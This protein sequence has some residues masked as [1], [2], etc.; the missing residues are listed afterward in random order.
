MAGSGGKS[1]Y[2][3][4]MEQPETAWPLRREA[5]ESERAAMQVPR[6]CFRQREPQGQNVLGLQILDM[7]EEQ[8]PRVAG[9]E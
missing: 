5:E 1:G 7:W 8:D 9:V 2:H 4:C 3:G 6:G